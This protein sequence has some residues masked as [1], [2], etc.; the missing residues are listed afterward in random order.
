MKKIIKSI[1]I[2]SIILLFISISKKEEGISNRVYHNNNITINYPYFNNK[3]IDNYIEEFIINS[4][5]TINTFIDYD[6]NLIDNNYHV[7]F[8]I[9]KFNNN[10]IKKNVSV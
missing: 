6:Y 4:T 10:I 8:Y 2:L 5:S 1:C 7:N 9:Y 3:K